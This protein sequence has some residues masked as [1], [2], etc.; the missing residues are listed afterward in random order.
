MST[1][2]DVVTQTLAS[3]GVKRIWGVTGD[4]LNGITASI[5]SQPPT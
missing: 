5:G 4:S 2:A 3:A 1:I